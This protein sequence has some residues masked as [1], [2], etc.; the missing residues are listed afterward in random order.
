MIENNR[1]YR[2]SCFKT[3]LLVAS[4]IV[5]ILQQGYA[6]AIR[7]FNEGLR[8]NKFFLVQQETPDNAKFFSAAKCVTMSE[9]DAYQYIRQYQSI[10][11]L[12]STPPE[13]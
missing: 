9:K 7:D 3:P 8:S 13:K 1:T 6:K 11:V 5:A 4:L 10:L 12:E 2:E